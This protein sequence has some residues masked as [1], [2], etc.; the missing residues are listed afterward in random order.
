MTEHTV[1]YF[2]A[3]L[4]GRFRLISEKG[5]LSENC[6]YQQPYLKNIREEQPCK[7]GLNSYQTFELSPSS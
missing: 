1:F 2:L 3:W 5:Y 4:A 7:A 6:P